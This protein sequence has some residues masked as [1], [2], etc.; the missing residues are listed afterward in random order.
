MLHIDKKATFGRALLLLVTIVWGSSF[1]VLKDTLTELGNGKFTF[2]VLA[3]RFL[4]SGI[5]LSLICYKKLITIKKS[6]FFKGLLLG[7]I[8]FG[9]YGVQTVGL[10]Y[11]TP[12]KNA[13]LTAVYVVIVPFLSWLFLSKKPT[14]NNCLGAILCMVGI[15]FV[16]IIGKNEHGSK[17]FL[18]DMLS[19]GSGIFYAFQIIFI[20][21]HA[22][23]EDV[24]QLLIVE[25]LTV[26]LICTCITCAIE[27]PLHY[28]EFSIP[29][30]SV[31]KI[32]YL[33]F[34][35]TLFA[36]FGQMIAQKHTPAMSVALIFS[37]ESV[38]GV[39]FE[40]LLG[41]ARI[42]AYMVIGF[43]LIFFAEIISEIGFKNLFSVFKRAEKKD[44][45]DERSSKG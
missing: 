25:I 43:V 21:K 45:I 3:F 19:L 34:A 30:G 32:L 29:Q 17:E 41:D 2:F 23:D 24:I 1:V 12:S 38:F 14:F 27:F 22:Q 9:A 8:L 33:A 5:A 6:T 37:L 42:T 4:L 18:G 7:C 11:T 39:I 28:G 31:W 36:Q 15:A 10:K 13:F 40:I 16:A 35:C 44:L 26:A 20:S